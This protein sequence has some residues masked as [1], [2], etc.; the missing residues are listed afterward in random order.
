M[1]YGIQVYDQADYDYYF[2]TLGAQVQ[3][4]LK[5]E[6]T[7]SWMEQEAERRLQYALL[8]ARNQMVMAETSSR[9]TLAIFQ[10]EM[11]TLTSLHQIAAETVAECP[12]LQDMVAGLLRQR[13]DAYIT[14]MAALR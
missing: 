13:Q 1:E 14:S 6:D 7:S 3:A 11:G 5:G 10:Q 12:T 9:K 8:K 2:D 4:A